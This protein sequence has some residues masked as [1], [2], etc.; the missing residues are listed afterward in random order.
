MDTILDYGMRW[1]IECL[2]SD[3][4][5]RGFGITKTHL[6]HSSYWSNSLRIL[7]V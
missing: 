1:G 6:K 3:F 4:K 2:F 7:S 5:S